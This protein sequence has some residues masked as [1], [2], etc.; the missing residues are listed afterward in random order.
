MEPSLPQP[1]LRVWLYGVWNLRESELAS[2]IFCT[3]E[4]P[5]KAGA[6]ITTKAAEFTTA[7]VWNREEFINE[8]AIG[9]P[10]VCR[11]WKKSYGRPDIFLGEAT[12]TCSQ[13]FPYGFQD[14]V[15]MFDVSGGLVGRLQMAVAPQPG[16]LD[17]MITYAT[18]KSMLDPIPTSSSDDRTHKDA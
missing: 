11:I 5:G 8:Y 9:D 1:L 15:N 2:Y 13:I 18:P 17:S 12:L 3:C 16:T 14:E 7:V 4:V 10:L 6:R